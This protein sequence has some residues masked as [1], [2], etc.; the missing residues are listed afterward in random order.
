M[1]MSCD[2][3]KAL[4]EGCCEL[5]NVVSPYGAQSSVVPVSDVS[6]SLWHRQCGG[7]AEM[8]LRDA[9]APCKCMH[10]QPGIQGPPGPK[11]GVK[12]H[13]SLHRLL[14]WIWPV[15]HSPTGSQRSSWRTWRPRKTRKLGKYLCKSSLCYLII[16]EVNRN[17]PTLTELPSP[18]TLTFIPSRPL[19]WVQPWVP[20]ATAW[21]FW[22]NERCHAGSI[23]L[24][25][26]RDIRSA[27][28]HEWAG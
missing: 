8:G 6:K 15:F 26:R 17:K 10:G 2:P 7:Y 11:V 22:I 12:T 18:A 23:S 24:R 19:N 25:L 9:P 20:S 4:S 1:E 5:S 3:E 16:W 14:Q 27:V 13:E 21:P 28:E